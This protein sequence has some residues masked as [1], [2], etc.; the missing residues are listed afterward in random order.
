MTTMKMIEMG[1][2]EINSFLLLNGR[3]IKGQ[4]S[5]RLL[6]L[7]QEFTLPNILFLCYTSLL[8][9]EYAILN[10]SPKIFQH[11]LQLHIM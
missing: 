1:K 8:D 5:Q 9:I 7:D 2:L 11:Y 3:R 10:H 6:A 4:Y